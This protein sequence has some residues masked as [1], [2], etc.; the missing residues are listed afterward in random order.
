FLPRLGYKKQTSLIQKATRLI[1]LEE[2]IQL[3][4][5][6]GLISEK[7]A[8]DLLSLPAE[9]RATLSALFDYLQPGTGKQIRIVMLSRD[10]ALRSQKTVSSLFHEQDFKEILEHAEMNPPQKTHSIL[11]LLQKKFYSRSS[12]AE[13]IFKERV[14]KLK[15][16]GNYEISHSLNFEKNEVYLTET[17]PDLECCEIAWSRRKQ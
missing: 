14:R 13:Q 2:T 17:F 5:H 9:D 11:E 10:I 6:H 12:A 8:F 16:P 7:I 1:T 15:L 4:V 3:Q